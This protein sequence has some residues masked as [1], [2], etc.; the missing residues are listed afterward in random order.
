MESSNKI[1]LNHDIYPL[2]DLHTHNGFYR[3]SGEVWSIE[4]GIKVAKKKGINI[5]G[6]SPKLESPKQNFI[7]LLRNELD[8]L[9]RKEEFTYIQSKSAEFQVYLGIELDIRITNG[10]IL[11]NKESYKYLDF[12]LAAPHQMP[13]RSLVWDLEEDELDEYFKILHDTLYYSFKKND[14]N[15]W[16]HPF[17][18]EIEISADMYKSRLI[19]LFRD[20]LEICVNKNMALEINENYFRVKNPPNELLN[21]NPSIKYDKTSIKDLLA[22]NSYY[23]R[24]FAFLKELFTIAIKEYKMKFTFGSDTHDLNKVGDIS[25]CIKFARELGLRSKDIYVLNN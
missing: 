17:L 20:V 14:L 18:Q 13:H 2:I 8:Q 1:N 24:K 11:L 10:S 6:I 3:G 22:D 5:L 23:K 12:I 19:D 4:E 16:A 25:E 9:K 21:A 15:I 7:K